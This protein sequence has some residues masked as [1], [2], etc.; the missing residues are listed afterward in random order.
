VSDWQRR[1]RPGESLRIPAAAYNAFVDAAIA[2]RR[3]S[4]A[5]DTSGAYR[6]ADVVDAINM[7]T[8]TA[9]EPYQVIRAGIVANNLTGTPRKPLIEIGNVSTVASQRTESLTVVAV[10]YIRPG[11]VGKVAVSGAVFA[12]CARPGGVNLSTGTIVGFVGSGLFGPD[13]WGS[14]VVLSPGIG[15]DSAYRVH[16]VRL[17]VGHGAWL[18]QIDP[19]PT[20]IGNAARWSYGWEEVR[21]EGDGGGSFETFTGNRT[22][23]TTGEAINILELGNTATIAYGIPVAGANFSINDTGVRFRAVPSGTVVKMWAT[24]DPRNGDSRVVFEAPNPVHG[25]CN[26]LEQFAGSDDMSVGD[27]EYALETGG[28]EAENE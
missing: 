14:A 27:D 25:P 11:E 16:L 3:G 5:G 4:L 9:F 21:Y 19:N 1:A 8:S 24:S 22:S 17:G 13:S 23:V 28:E 12:R 2:V 26:T 15:T 10:D 7:G 20:Q 18:A 6:P